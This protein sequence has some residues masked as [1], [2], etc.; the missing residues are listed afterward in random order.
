MWEIRLKKLEK[1][2]GKLIKLKIFHGNEILSH[3]IKL[4][5]NI[6][7]SHK[8]SGKKKKK[9]RKKEKKIKVEK[10]WEIH[11]TKTKNISWEN[12]IEMNSISSRQI[13]RFHINFYFLLKNTKRGGRISPH[14]DF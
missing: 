12:K 9:E 5:K 14:D 2:S 7:N 6:E 10:I 11:E 13:P 8:K 1:K 4:P 3:S